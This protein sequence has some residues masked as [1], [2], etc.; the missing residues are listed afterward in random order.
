MKKKSVSGLFSPTT[1]QA[2]QTWKRPNME[3]VQ[4]GENDPFLEKFGPVSMFEPFRFWILVSTRVQDSLTTRRHSIFTK[5][6]EKFDPFPCL[7][8]FVFGFWFPREI[9]ILLPP[10]G[11]GHRLF[12]RVQAPLHYSQFFQARNLPY[13]FLSQKRGFPLATAKK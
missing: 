1:S 3:T 12:K 5:F 8:H 4:N 10:E 6:L 7:D 9:G 13:V 11:F 2:V